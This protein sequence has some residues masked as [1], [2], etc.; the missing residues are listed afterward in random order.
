M[1]VIDLHQFPPPHEEWPYP[2][3]HSR[4]AEY[5]ARVVACAR[6]VRV[7]C[8]PDSEE[9]RREFLRSIQAWTVAEAF[10]DEPPLPTD[11]VPKDVRMALADGLSL[12][13]ALP[14][15]A[16]SAGY[17]GAVSGNILLFILRCAEHSP[18]D[19]SVLKAVDII[20]RKLVRDGRRI[21]KQG[22]GTIAA[23]RSAIMNAWTAFKPV[24]HFWAATRLWQLEDR[25]T[26]WYYLLF[27]VDDL[28][29]F[30]ALA[31]EL[32]QR[33]EALYARGQKTL[34][35]SVLDPSAAWRVPDSLTLP[36]IEVTLPPLTDKEK[37][38]LTEYRAE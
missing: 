37:S 10:T 1:P 38:W 36:N 33:G 8:H 20:G 6:V 13:R 19:M 21:R 35:R 25:V 2:P 3:G 17:G 24:A 28:L 16:K 14:K 12:H 15:A 7:M 27:R 18:K 34:D 32:R 5:D 9:D 11:M 29:E 31:E 22:E 30:I 4:K 26:D 23:S